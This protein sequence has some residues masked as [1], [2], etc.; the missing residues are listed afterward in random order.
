M[1][2]G[3]HIRK[4]EIKD[5]Q[6][7]VV[8]TQE[9]YNAPKNKAGL[10]TNAGKF[11]ELLEDFQQGKIKTLVATLDQKIIGSIRYNF[12]DSESLYFSKLAVKK[13]YRNRGIGTQIIKYIESIAK[14]KK[15][16][17]ILLDCMFE[18]G[19]VPYYE[20]LG[21]K[22]DNIKKHQDHHDVDMSKKL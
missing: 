15:C 17:K 11:S 21:Y 10:V 14:E 4:A 18:K 7:I 6:E 13:E 5:L 2:Q 9:A 19:L 1:K 16:K 3:I 8:I 20:N 22:I 12:P